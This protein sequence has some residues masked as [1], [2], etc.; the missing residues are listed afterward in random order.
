MTEPKPT[1]LQAIEPCPVCHKYMT[2]E[3]GMAKVKLTCSCG[4]QFE[5]A[6]EPGWIDKWNKRAMTEPNCNYDLTCH[7]AICTDCEHA[8]AAD[9]VIDAQAREID[10][11]I[12]RVLHLEGENMR[13]TRALAEH[14][15]HP[16]KEPPH[17]DGELRTSGMKVVLTQRIGYRLAHYWPEYAAWLESWTM[18]QLEGVVTWWELPGG[19][20]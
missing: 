19:T 15:G 3:I 8:N 16:G 10:Q 17:V 18:L 12:S 4:N 6:F 11:L 13:L 14:D 7:A 9:A 2:I 20:K 5:T 1:K